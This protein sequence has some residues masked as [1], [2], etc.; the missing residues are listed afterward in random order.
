MDNERRLGKMFTQK[1][2]VGRY[3]V[4]F[5]VGVFLLLICLVPSVSWAEKIIKVG[6]T[7]AFT[8][9]AAQWAIVSKADM[10]SIEAYINSK[11]GITVKGETYKVNT[12]Y[13]D[14]KYTVAGGRAAGEKLIY[15]DKV[16]FFVGSFGSDPI[17]GWAPLATKEKKVAV[18]GSTAWNPKPEWPYLFRLA[19]NDDERSNALCSLAKEKLG[20][21]SIYY[22]F[23]DDLTGKTGKEGA[24]K[25]EK[26][27]GL[28]VKGSVTVPVSTT[29]FYPFLGNA[30]KTNPDF[31]LCTTPPGA[32][33]LIV[34]QARELGYKGRIG[35]PSGIPGDI[36]KW[37]GI[38]GVEASKGFIGILLSYEEFSPAGLEYQA[39]RDKK[40][41]DIKSTVMSYPMQTHVLMMAIQKAQSFDPDEIAK[42]LRTGEFHSLHKLPLRASGEK[43]YGIKNHISNPVGYSTIVGED[44]TEYLG[45]VE[46]S[47]P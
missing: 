32:T 28:E 22:I 11:G 4:G 18:V 3:G 29:D 37:Q 27:R 44:K 40:F 5:L 12:I 31:L 25:F 33:A 9:P 36:K 23:A 13:A 41:P 21:K 19:A 34:K 7:N 46:V 17:A 47:T 16:D 26:T 24:A 10:D 20:C 1:H 38:A 45:F 30:L 15:I 42:V 14:D 8:G 39:L 43:T 2:W 35:C 6:V